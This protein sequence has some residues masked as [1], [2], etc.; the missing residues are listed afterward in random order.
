MEEM[1]KSSLFESEFIQAIYSGELKKIKELLSKN[2][3]LLETPS[4]NGL[5]PLTIATYI[6]KVEIVEYL[7]KAGSRLTPEGLS[8][9]DVDIRNLFSL[10]FKEIYGFN[11]GNV[12]GFVP[13][14]YLY[15]YIRAAA[16]LLMAS[17]SIQNDSSEYQ[18]EVN[19]LIQI[20]GAGIN[21]RNY[22]GKTA[23]RLAA[24]GMNSHFLEKLAS[25]ESIYFLKEHRE[26][27]SSHSNPVLQAFWNL[28]NL[29]KTVVECEKLYADNNKL[30]ILNLKATKE[31]LEKNAL[32]EMKT[33]EILNKKIIEITAFVKNILD[34]SGSLLNKEPYCSD[35]YYQL[36][37]ILRKMLPA[38]SAKY[39]F[40][41][42]EN[43]KRT[44]QYY[45]KANQL[46]FDLSLKYLDEVKVEQDINSDPR[47]EKLKKIVKYGLRSKKIETSLF[48]RVLS[49]I[50][51]SE[52][53]SGFGVDTTVNPKSVEETVFEVMSTLIDNRMQTTGYLKKVLK[54]SKTKMEI[55]KLYSLPYL[56]MSS[57]SK[58][59]NATSNSSSSLSSSSSSSF[60]N[61]E[62]FNR[63]EIESKFIQA[64]TLGD[65][66][67]VGYLLARNRKLLNE[68]SIDGLTPLMIAAH[69]KEFSIFNL[70]LREGA[71]FDHEVL[72]GCWKGCTTLWFLGNAKWWE[73]VA[74]L[75]EMGSLKMESRPENK[76]TIGRNA[77]LTLLAMAMYSSVQPSLIELLLKSGVRLF[78]KGVT[79]GNP[80][81][82]D[83]PSSVHSFG[84][85]S[86]LLSDSDPIQ[87]YSKA[88]QMYAAY[89]LLALAEGRAENE[90]W[91]IEEQVFRKNI[92]QNRLQTIL[93][94][95]GPGLNARMDNHKTA[96][97]ISTEKNNIK[98]LREL[99][100]RK[101]TFFLKEHQELAIKHEDPI[102]RAFGILAVLENTILKRNNREDNRQKV[103]NPKNNKEMKEMEEFLMSD[104]QE[105]RK[106]ELS[107]NKIEEIENLTQMIINLYENLKSEE[108]YCSKIYFE[109]GVLLK[110][111]FQD[112]QTPELVFNVFKK[113]KE[114]SHYFSK[115]NAVL[116]DLSLHP[117][118]LDKAPVI[119]KANNDSLISL[120]QDTE[121][122]LFPIP[123]SDNTQYEEHL[124]E[125]LKYA[126]KA[127]EN[128]VDKKMFFEIIKSLFFM[129]N[130][131]KC[132]Y[133]DELTLAEIIFEV[134]LAKL[135]SLPSQH[136]GMGSLEVKEKG[137][138]GRQ[139]NGMDLE[140]LEFDFNSNLCIEGVNFGM[141]SGS[142]SSSSSSSSSSASVNKDRK[143]KEPSKDQES[144]NANSIESRKAKRSKNNPAF[145]KILKIEREKEGLRKDNM[146]WHLNV[147]ESSENTD[148]NSNSSSST[149]SSLNANS[150]S[151]SSSSSSLN[152]NVNPVLE[153]NKR[154]NP[155]DSFDEGIE[156]SAKRI[157]SR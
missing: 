42:F 143:R 69:Y 116:F 113:I 132:N 145:T 25:I 114:T 71:D 30:L 150:S 49:S 112:L 127:D 13:S 147:P 24:E 73:Q 155:A 105:N 146:E 140:D 126:I 108:P 157:R 36:G 67:T 109:L 31:Q 152:S 121:M 84:F 7:L 142:N 141:Q 28:R 154:K 1:L 110:D 17:C 47:T 99:A 12:M 128:K 5:L 45:V 87:A 97:Q 123:E 35:I 79:Y 151:S 29:K 98:F 96:F 86:L 80:E 103:S 125:T 88:R 56:S 37:N 117:A 89:D 119:K 15:K 104:V 41:A 91:G 43:V 101:A 129:D 62:L 102:V 11:S 92:P 130:T 75:I 9:N 22:E 120:S 124:Y 64:I 156:K 59:N 137:D 44:S 3:L 6:G 136:F 14:C 8:E 57:N 48:K 53:R 107:E 90:F 34:L 134:G 66:K 2:R 20:L 65:E 4:S 33:K 26:I 16:S 18:Q 133:N 54:E 40:E 39:V 106:E 111:V 10:N 27:I 55:E 68:P 93:D 149:S 139:C 95:L 144:S 82:Y 76:R 94:I 122:D 52:D 153:K 50:L 100:S 19:D 131:L 63:V 77:S 61:F 32:N 81:F 60:R 72:A 58:M 46:L 148:S 115:A 74:L 83:D 78:P 85:P 51:N 38:I 138:T 23:L 70:L 135:R 118:L 21:G